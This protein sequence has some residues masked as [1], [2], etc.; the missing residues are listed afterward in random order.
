[1]KKKIICAVGTLAV[2]AITA[3][4]AYSNGHDKGYRK[5]LKDAEEDDLFY[6]EDDEDG[7]IVEEQYPSSYCCIG[8]YDEKEVFRLLRHITAFK[9]ISNKT[10][11]NFMDIDE[12]EADNIL[13]I[14]RNCGY[15]IGPV[16]GRNYLV[17]ITEEDLEDYVI[18]SEV[19][20]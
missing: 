17:K 14:I 13:D 1:M 5:G 16:D 10:V 2:T 9:Y 19:E 11:M 18:A 8:G 3:V 15:L 7:E 12:K 20:R 6:D 4:I